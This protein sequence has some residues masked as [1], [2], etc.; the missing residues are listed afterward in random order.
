[1][2]LFFLRSSSGRRKPKAESKHVTIDAVDM[3]KIVDCAPNP[4]SRLSFLI[5]AIAEP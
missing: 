5:L 2:G 1:M 4:Q 3:G